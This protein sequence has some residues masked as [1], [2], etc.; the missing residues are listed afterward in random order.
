MIERKKRNT[1]LRR[2]AFLVASSALP[3][4]GQSGSAAVQRAIAATQYDNIDFLQIT[5]RGFDALFG[6]AYDGDS[7]WP[8]FA[9]SRYRASVNYKDDS[10]VDERVRSQLQNPPLGGGNQP[11][12]EQRQTLLY[13]N[14]HAWNL[15]PQGKPTPAQLERDLRS[16]AE[17]RQLQILLTPPGFLQ[18]ASHAA[19]T[20]REE[21][22]G[23]RTKTIVAFTTANKVRLEGTIDEKDHLEHIRTWVD[24]P[25]LGDVV[26]SADFSHYRDFDGIVYP[27]HIVQSEGGYPLLDLTVSTVT[28]NAASTLEVPAIIEH[29]AAKEIPPI[30]PQ[31]YGAGIWI[32][33]GEDYHASKSIL[34]EF[35]DYLLVIEAPDS[36]Q[37][38]L[39]V[40]D[41]VHKLVPRKLIRYIVNTHTHFDHSGGLRTYAAE[42]ATVVTWDGNVTYYKQ[43]WSNPHTLHPDRLALAKRT[44]V[45]EGVVGNRTFSDGEQEIVVIHYAGNYHNPGMLAVYLPRQRALI[46]ADSLNPQV[47][48]NDPPTAIPNLVQF[49]AVV[50]KLGLPVDEIIPI[51]GR[52]AP[53]D[54][55]LKDIEA[56]KGAQIWP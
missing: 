16:A 1:I 29:T 25:V 22:A 41:A 49:Y 21:K 53:F 9:L 3:L 18:A 56:Y 54:E 2:A 35:K 45:F 23:T 14:G 13:R 43:V 36:E 44:P 42:G 52:V 47:D 4:H 46:E 19:S 28:K 5:G 31:P 6:Q 7:G 39:A 32:L 26:Y 48:P 27:E 12:N 33:P 8:R 10:L 34:V 40:I 30:K 20:V 51:H 15:S 38:S 11:I 24:T 55:G 50:A 37:R 17:A